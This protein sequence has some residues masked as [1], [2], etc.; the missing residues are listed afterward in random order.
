M[1][2]RYLYHP[3]H[4]IGHHASREWQF[5]RIPPPDEPYEIHTTHL[6]AFARTQQRTAAEAYWRPNFTTPSEN[7]TPEI[8]HGMIHYPPITRAM[9]RAARM[10]YWRNMTFMVPEL[11]APLPVELQR[12]AM[13]W[14]TE[15]YDTPRAVA[16]A[17]SV[18]Q[19]PQGP[20]IIGAELQ[21]MAMHW[22]TEVYAQARAAVAAYWRNSQFIHPDVA[23][24]PEELQRSLMHWPDFARAQPRAG[25]DAYRILQTPPIPDFIG[26]ELQR[27][28]MHWPDRGYA[29]PYAALAAY[30]R[31]NDLVVPELAPLSEELL[32]TLYPLFAR[33]A[34]R[35]A[36]TAYMLRALFPDIVDAGI[37]VV[38]APPLFRD[39]ASL[40]MQ[41]GDSA[42]IAIRFI[43][44]GTR[45]LRNS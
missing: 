12:F 11:A 18:L 14:P 32:T 4:V 40:H 44:L 8:Q 28:L 6:P 24:F 30:W 23:P 20:E 21:R 26:P 25:A 33:Q 15:V 22:P 38:P 13:H 5:P 3:A 19:A 41:V 1:I 34:P 37:A 29:R 16:T 42:S 39:T 36:V 45:H 17:Y 7:V 31:R 43:N 27:M 9:P 10:A 35:A 2:S